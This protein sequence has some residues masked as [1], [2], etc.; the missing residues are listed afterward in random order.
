MKHCQECLESY[1]TEERYCMICGYE[2]QNIEVPIDQ[3]I[4]A[5]MSSIFD[6]FGINETALAN[7]LSE[8][9]PKLT[10]EVMSSLGKMT[11]DPNGTI[12]YSCTIKVGPFKFG[13]ISSDF[14]LIPFNSLDNIR[15]L[16][17][18]PVCG[19]SSLSNCDIGE[20]AGLLFFRGKVTFGSKALLAQN[21][22][23]K[24]VIISQNEKKWPFLMT[25]TAS[26]QTIHIPVLMISETNGRIFRRFLEEKSPE[27]II[28]SI[29]C[30][31]VDNYCIICQENMTTNEVI[32]RLHC[33]H[34]Y[35][36]I[37]LDRW[38]EGHITCPVCRLNLNE[39]KENIG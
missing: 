27:V 29:E 37:C 12:F 14:S 26:T 8:S 7:Y 13:A 2:L 33:G 10:K 38:L 32:Y 3:N 6:L 5:Q 20:N 35:H 36:D 4:Q 15:F 21:L 9:N 25:D 28:G 34:I 22:G 30:T 24:V 23:A 17:A 16:V 11:V 18:N 39:S 1:E 19:E 31:K